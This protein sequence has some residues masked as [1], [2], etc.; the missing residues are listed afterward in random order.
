MR[1]SCMMSEIQSIGSV[2]AN[3]DSR[4]DILAADKTVIEQICKHCYY[5]P[6]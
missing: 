2:F 5:K 3:R 4:I 6:I 1:F